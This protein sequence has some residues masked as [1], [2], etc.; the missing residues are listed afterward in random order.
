MKKTYDE[1]SIK[2][3]GELF[4]KPLVILKP[5]RMS[6]KRWLENLFHTD[7]RE[8]AK[9][10]AKQSFNLMGLYKETANVKVQGAGY[11]HVKWNALL[12]VRTD[13]ATPDQI[14]IEIQSGT[15]NK[16]QVFQLNQEEWSRTLPFLKKVSE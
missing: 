14:D 10:R 3:I 4:I 12:W 1:G 13:T 5:D 7:D 2:R 6:L 16:S 15:G 9:Y 11:R 8:I